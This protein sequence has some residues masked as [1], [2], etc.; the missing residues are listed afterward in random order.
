MALDQLNYQCMNIEKRDNGEYMLEED[1]EGGSYRWCS[2]DARRLC[3]GFVNPP[4][5]TDPDIVVI[6]NN[7]SLNQVF[8]S[9]FADATYGSRVAVVTNSWGPAWL[10]IDALK[11]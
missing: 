2:L 5:A 10:A 11:P 4:A 9:L 1:R 6:P 8:S 7:G 3:A